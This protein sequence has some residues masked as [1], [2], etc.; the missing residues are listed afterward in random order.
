MSIDKLSME[1]TPSEHRNVFINI[2]KTKL[3]TI[4]AGK[5]TGIIDHIKGLFELLILLNSTNVLTIC[6]SRLL[7]IVTDNL[8]KTIVNNDT[9]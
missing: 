2:S 6:S 5:A 4:T 3:L 7:L 1:T 8:P 9:S